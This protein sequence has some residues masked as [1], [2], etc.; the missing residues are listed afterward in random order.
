[1]ILDKDGKSINDLS[2]AL[3]Q[4]VTDSVLKTFSKESKCPVILYDQFGKQINKGEPIK[5]KRYEK[6]EVNK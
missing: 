3:L 1:M 6:I 4:R 5:F 2:S